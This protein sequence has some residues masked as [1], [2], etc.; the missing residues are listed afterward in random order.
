MGSHRPRG[1]AIALDGG[2]VELA[3]VADPVQAQP[4]RQPHQAG[5]GGRLVHHRTGVVRDRGQRRDLAGR[6]VDPVVQPAVDERAHA[7]ARRQ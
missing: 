2:P 7:E 6:A 4:V 5:R 1:S 3:G